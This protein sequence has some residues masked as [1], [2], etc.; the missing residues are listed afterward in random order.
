MFKKF[1]LLFTVLITVVSYAQTYDISGKV[2]DEKGEA[3]VGATVVATPGNYG[4]TT[5]KDGKYSLKKLPVNLYTVKVSFVGYSNASAQ[6]S[7]NNDET[8]NFTLKSS[9]LQTGEVIVEV[10]RARERETPVAFS[11]ID[12]K[13]IEEKIHGQDAPLMTRGVPGVFAYS[14]DGV[15]N[16]EAQLFVRGFSQ[17]Y[18]QVLINGIPT[19]DPESNAV[20][21]SNWGSVSSNAASIQIQRGA[22]SSLY[23][24]GSFGGSFNIVTE[25]AP[26]LPYYGVNF[27]LGDPK[28]TMYGIRYN[29]GLVADQFAVA[30]NIDR[31]VGEGSRVSGRYE[32]LNYY[33]SISYYPQA[34]QS[35]KLVLHGAPQEHGYSFSNSVAYFKKFGYKANSANFLPVSVVKALPNNLTSGLANYGL[36]DDSRELVDDEFV[37]LGH[38][39]FHKPQLELHYSLDLDEVSSIHATGFYS[40]GRGGGSSMNSTGTLFSFSGDTLVTNRYNSQGYVDNVGIADTIYLKNAYQRISYS[41]HQQIGLIANY[42]TKFGKNLDLT[43]GGELRSWSADHPGHFTNLF[44]KSSV[45]QSYAYKDATTG[46]IKTFS[47]KVYQGD[48]DGPADDIG[49]PSGWNLSNTDPT[50]R[51]QYRNYLGETPQFTLFA[52]GNYKFDNLNIMGSLQYVWYKYKL[53]ENMPSENAIGKQLTA[54]EVTSLNLTEEGP[55]G[56]KFYMKDNAATTGWYEFELVRAERSRGFFQPKIGFNYNVN[57]NFNVFANFAHVERFVDLGVYYNQGRVFPDAE[58]EKS[59]QIEVGTGFVSEELS[60]KLNGFY[61]I[62]DNKSARI[63]DLS[64][65]GQPGYDRNGFRTELVGTSKN[66]G[67]EFEFGLDLEKI[68]PLKGFALAGSFTTMSNTWTEI[69]DKVLTDANLGTLQEDLNLN[70][71][72]DAG[73]DT[74]GDNRLDENRRVFNASARD[75]NGAVNAL[76]FSE[77]KDK[78]VASGP[79]TMMSLNLSYEYEN[80]TAGLGMQM[81]SNNV[82]LD[83][84][85]YLGVD[86]SWKTVG[87]KEVFTTVWDNVLPTLT[88]FDLSLGYKFTYSYFKGVATVQVNNL[89]DHEG[90][91]AADRFGV[92]PES[93]RSVRLNVSL[94]F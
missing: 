15:G 93:L 74:D 63:Q 88:T 40:V 60:A 58:D 55:R 24:A 16:G 37:N 39:F 45:T 64:Q 48:L 57:K 33:T 49:F 25:D 18:V 90:F 44:G 61:M 21:W 46:A 17:N 51:T 56:S 26:P 94:G 2:T 8:L 65:A 81:L 1:F 54:A 3:L 19:N 50:Y 32:G 89:F 7:L 23:G 76:Y 73:E 12:G 83:G 42:R 87:T 80:F 28:L 22:G 20:Y 78:K 41:L 62:W 79:Q 31:K 29:S 77:L 30:V 92:I 91:I 11:T 38:N 68:L 47:R 10:N 52:Q 82:L 5:D 70:G 35:L 69:L 72:L 85:S 43:V 34:N 71:K 6:V 75:A 13:S 66:I 14:T 59:N 67:V 86:G 27:S 36:M 53:T 84:E 9:S 4:T